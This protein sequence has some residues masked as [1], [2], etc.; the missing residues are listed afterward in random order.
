[1]VEG[2]G[3]GLNEMKGGGRFESFKEASWFVDEK[4]P[5]HL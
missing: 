5:F 1:M 2:V 3:S 4:Q